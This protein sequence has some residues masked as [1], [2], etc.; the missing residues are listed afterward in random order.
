MKCSIIFLSAV[1]AGVVTALP[2]AR[3]T[4]QI[5]IEEW[6]VVSHLGDPTRHRLRDRLLPVVLVDFSIMVLTQKSDTLAAN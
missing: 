5:D 1:M 2:I 6:Y 3:G 4:A